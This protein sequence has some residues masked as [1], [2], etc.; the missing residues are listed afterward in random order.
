MTIT[1]ANF[2]QKIQEDA[3]IIIDKSKKKRVSFGLIHNIF[4]TTILSHTS[5]PDAL[6]SLLAAKLHADEAPRQTLQKLFEDVLLS[7]IHI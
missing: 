2:W 7:L 3:S 1:Q 5:L 4:N 6:A